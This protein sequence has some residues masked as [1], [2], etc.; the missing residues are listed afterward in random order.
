MQPG[1]QPGMQAHAAYG[2]PPAPVMNQAGLLTQT[3]FHNAALGGMAPQQQ[4]QQQQQQGSLHLTQ[5]PMGAAVGGASAQQR[6]S[7][8]RPRS[9]ARAGA[10]PAPKSLEG[11]RFRPRNQS[12]PRSQPRATPAG[13][14]KGK[15]LTWVLVALG[16]AVV[17]L[18]AWVASS[19]F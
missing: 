11:T 19:F 12:G 1:M 4:Q 17:G 5:R 16:V 7:A 9:P 3:G 15:S 13:A 6:S 14:R 18:L 8:P 10:A 2:A